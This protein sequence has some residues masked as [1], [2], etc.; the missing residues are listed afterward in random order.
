MTGFPLFFL[1]FA[2]VLCA[3]MITFAVETKTRRTSMKLIADSGSTKTDWCLAEGGRAVR[4][5]T[6]RGINPFHQDAGEIYAIVESELLPQLGDAEPAEVHFYGSGCRAECVGAMAEMLGR[7][8][9]HARTVSVEGDL[10]GAARALCGRS[11][12]IACILG[13]GSNSCLYDGMEIKA[14]TPPLGYILGDE[15]SGAVLGREFLNA[16]YKGRL[17]AEVAE[18]FACETRLGVADV[19][20]RVYREPQANRFLSSLSQFIHRHISDESLRALV[21]DNFRSFFR[22]NVLPY[23]R[24]ELE[25][26]VVGSVGYYYSAE[27][28]EAAEAE[29]VRLGTVE[30]SPMAGLVRYHG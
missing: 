2:F 25:V 26:S 18:A 29:G 3:I 4:T 16:L 1:P 27:L 15:G 21:R 5:V 14:N 10:L 30:R 13:T 17:S 9:T 7:V 6:T 19:V 8:F 11:E 20:R 24:P 28:S 23:G 12:G 22:N